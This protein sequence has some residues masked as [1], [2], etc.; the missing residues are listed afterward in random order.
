M[1]STLRFIGT[2]H[3]SLKRL[4]DCPMLENENAPAASI[5][6]FAEFAEGIKDIKSGDEILLFTWLHLADRSVLSTHPRNDLTNPLT[7]VFSTR[8]PDRPNP[9]GIHKVKVIALAAGQIVVSGLEVLD[10][11][12]VIDIKPA[13]RAGVGR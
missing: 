8:S 2:I 5:E 10:Q 3:S 6:I 13:L 4:E 9:I 1:D 7:G 12:P 11:T